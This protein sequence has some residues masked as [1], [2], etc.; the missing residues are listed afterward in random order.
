[1]IMVLQATYFYIDFDKHFEKFTEL[2]KK[3]T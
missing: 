1:M 2:M 3:G